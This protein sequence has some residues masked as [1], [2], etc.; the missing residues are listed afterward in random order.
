MEFSVIFVWVVLV[1]GGGWAFWNG[2]L[3]TF[4]SL[5][6]FISLWTETRPEIKYTFYVYLFVA[7][8]SGLSFSYQSGKDSLYRYRNL[9]KTNETSDKNYMGSKITSDYEAVRQ[10]IKHD[11]IENGWKALWWPFHIAENVACG[12]VLYLNPKTTQ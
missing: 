5:N 2:T 6:T 10:G 8:L 3:L 9:R 11:S 7:I 1:M 12:I 4:L